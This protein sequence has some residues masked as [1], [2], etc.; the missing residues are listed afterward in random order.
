[1]KIRGFG[2]AGAWLA[3][4]ALGASMAG[5]LGSQ[6]VAIDADSQYRLYL[7]V[8]AFDRAFRT[9]SGGQ[10][11]IGVLFVKGL[12]ESRRARDEIVRAITAG[13][14]AFDGQPIVVVP[15][16]YGSAV[17]IRSALEAKAVDVLYVTPI[18][19]LSIEP[20]GTACR[21]ARVASFTGVPEYIRAGLSVSFGMRGRRAG[22]LVN[23]RNSRSEGSDF[24]ARFLEVVTVVDEFPGGGRP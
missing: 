19:P 20:V 17:E 18:D 4:L 23:R 7:K 6:E 9:R 21:A 1:M 22:I 5:P 15:V 10:M 3:V 2:R 8:L 12:R 11:T 24:S 14:A 13:P 16:E